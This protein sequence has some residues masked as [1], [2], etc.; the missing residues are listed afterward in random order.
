M[1]KPPDELINIHVYKKAGESIGI[2][3]A[4]NCAQTSK[5]AGVVEG[6][7]LH[8]TNQI[9]PGDLVITLNDNPVQDESPERLMELL[10][11]VKEE[12]EVSLTLQ[13]SQEL[14]R[15]SPVQAKIIP[16][17][18]VENLV[19]T[20]PLNEQ[21]PMQCRTGHSPRMRKQPAIGRPNTFQH[22]Q[23]VN[24]EALGPKPFQHSK[25]LEEDSNK[26]FHLKPLDFPTKK[27]SLT[28]ENKQH[29]K[30]MMALQPSKSLDLSSLPQ[31][32]TRSF[33]TLHNYWN[34]E[35]TTDRLHTNKD[36]VSWLVSTV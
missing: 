11:E 8:R 2:A 15:E 30:A 6:S 1:S 25:P 9:A 24:I 29:R 31:W 26:P 20:S 5:V 35:Q 21:T 3:F 22:A 7:P 12:E 34:G 13:R 32:R 10:K 4:R 36:I 19:N 18:I 16:P 33:V 28:P 14:P 17:T 23:F 27:L